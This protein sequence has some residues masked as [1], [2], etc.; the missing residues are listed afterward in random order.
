MAVKKM[1][2]QVT[3]LGKTSAKHAS[4]KE[5]MSRIYKDLLQLN[6]KKN[7]MPKISKRFKQTPHNGSYTNSQ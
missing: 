4:G 1:S 6:S 3:D 7:P 2:R 5:L